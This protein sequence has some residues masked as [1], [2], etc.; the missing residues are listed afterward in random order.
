MITNFLAKI[1]KIFTDKTYTL[2][3]TA[4]QPE[5]AP[6]PFKEDKPMSFF[7]ESE[8]MCHCGCKLLPQQSIID[9]L[10]EIRAAY[11]KAITLTSVKRCEAHNKKIGGAPK[12]AHVEGIAADLRRSPDLLKF[13]LDNAERFGIWIEDPTKTATWIHIDLR[14]RDVGPSHVFRI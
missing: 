4:V 13:I 14:K 9:K 1:N 11:G 6:E 5:K 10:D 12:S 2:P 7:T 3:A 8:L